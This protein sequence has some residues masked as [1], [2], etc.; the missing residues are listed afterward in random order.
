[1]KISILALLPLVAGIIGGLIGGRIHRKNKSM[2]RI[3]KND[4][5]N[6]GQTAKTT[7]KFLCSFAML[8]FVALNLNAANR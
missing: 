8:M 5:P 3:D 4:E 6:N 1:M 2:K 7:N